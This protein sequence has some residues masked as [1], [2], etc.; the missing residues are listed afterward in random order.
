MIIYLGLIGRVDIFGTD[1]AWLY[2]WDWLG[3]VIYLWL[4]GRGY[5]TDWAW[6]NIWEWLGVVIYLRLIG[7]CYSTDRLPG[8]SGQG[9]SH[10]A[11]PEVVISRCPRQTSF[12]R[13]D[14][15][16]TGNWKTFERTTPTVV[17]QTRL[18]GSEKV[19]P[20]ARLVRGMPVGR[21]GGVSIP[22]V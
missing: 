14:M 1:G 15:C 13:T 10:R 11:Q 16:F 18:P 22:S 19:A 4:I 7:S 6:L 12:L 9:G 5:G 3:V 2:I 8:S 17:S 21:G 20:G